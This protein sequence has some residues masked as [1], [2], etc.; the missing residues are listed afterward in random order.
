MGVAVIGYSLVIFT[1]SI[2]EWQQMDKKLSVVILGIGQPVRGDDS[3][4]LEVVR[5]WQKTYPATANDPRLRV[6]EAAVPGLELID[7][8]AGADYAMLVDAVQSGAAPGTLH[9]VKPEQVV[10]YE[11]GSNSAHGWGVAE[12]IALAREVRYS[13]PEQIAI[14]GIEAQS[15]EVG[16]PMTPA[17]R[18][19]LAKAAEMLEER[20]QWWL[21]M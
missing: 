11:S 15:F 21:F 5:L 8:L 18:A 9:L 7:L 17:V 3:A 12:T 1:I 6:Q 16:A 10:S 14:L 20:I 13:L 2:I 19:S 4:G